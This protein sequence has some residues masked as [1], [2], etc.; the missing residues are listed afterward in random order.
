M[1]DHT[2]GS[3][4]LAT[5]MR[6]FGLAWFRY[7]R[8]C[9]TR[10]AMARRQSSIALG[11]MV[12]RIVMRGYGS[13]CCCARPLLC[14]CGNLNCCGRGPICVVAAAAVWPLCSWLRRWMK[15][16]STFTV[17]RPFDRQKDAALAAD[18]CTI[19]AALCRLGGSCARCLS[20]RASQERLARSCLL[21][22]R[23]S[24]CV[25]AV[26]VCIFAAVGVILLSLLFDFLACLGRCFPAGRLALKLPFGLAGL[27]LLN[28]LSHL[29][30]MS[31]NCLR[32]R[33][34]SG[35]LV[36]LWV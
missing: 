27:V 33:L 28:A 21:A 10:S 2:F 16:S 1:Y 35:V 34:S 25:L 26:A 22:S 5:L 7:R 4:H 24:A 15:C 20:A 31:L 30:I 23:L 29:H 14:S 18:S 32:C 11:S 3:T 13:C 8:A 12:R 36:I 19:M 9:A 6:K 17:V